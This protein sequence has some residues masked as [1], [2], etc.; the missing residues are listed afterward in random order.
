MIDKRTL[1]ISQLYDDNFEKLKL[2]WVA[3]VGVERFV[4]LQDLATGT[5]KKKPRR[6]HLRKV[7]KTK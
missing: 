4:R 7:H 6:F 2:T 5:T 1:S 3:A